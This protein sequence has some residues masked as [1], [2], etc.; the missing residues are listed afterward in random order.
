MQFANFTAHLSTQLGIQV[1]QWFIKQED[2]RLTHNGAPHRHT[3]AL[4]AG[5]IFRQAL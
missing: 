3:L 5:E 2:L 4:T 1:R